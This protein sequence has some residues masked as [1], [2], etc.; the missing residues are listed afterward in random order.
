MRLV[1]LLLLAALLSSCGGP[2]GSRPAEA[3]GRGELELL[4]AEVEELRQL[5]TRGPLVITHE[6]EGPAILVHQKGQGTALVVIQ[7]TDNPACTLV[8]QGNAAGLEVRQR[9]GEDA[10]ECLG[11][12]VRC[13][14]V[15]LVGE[16]PHVAL[17]PHGTIQWADPLE[18][19]E[20]YD[21]IWMGPT[22]VEVKEQP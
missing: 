19:L 11:G 16:R 12:D 15:I 7:E 20:Y 3:Q 9:D 17:A 18:P 8:A 4:R 14:Q 10:I 1:A 5:V 2:P 21:W 6:G 13:E 22:G